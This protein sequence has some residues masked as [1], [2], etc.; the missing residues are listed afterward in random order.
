MPR[1]KLTQLAVD[2]LTWARAVAKWCEEDPK[3]RR[4]KEPGRV[5]V[6][7]TQLAEFGLIVRPSGRKTWQTLYRVDGKTVRETLGTTT[8]V[9]SVSDARK[10]G[11]ASMTKARSG[12]NPVAEKREAEAEKARQSAEEAKK[13]APLGELLGQYLDK[14]PKVNQ[15]GKPLAAEYLAEIERALKRDVMESDL[16]VR[17]ITELADGK[18]IKALLYDMA[19]SR[20]SHARH[21]H[22]YLR[23]AAEWL[24]DNDDRVEKNFMASIK[25]PAPKVE[26]DRALGS[27]HDHEVRLFW[28]ACDRVEWPF[29]DFFKLLLLLGPRRD[30][31]AF[32]TWDEFDLPNRVWRL[33]AERVKNDEGVIVHLPQ[34]A[35]D[36]FSSLKHVANPRNYLFCSA[37]RGTDRPI[38]GFSHAAERVEKIMQQMAATDGLPP[39][40]HFTRHD[41][42]RSLATGMAKLGVAPHVAD[43]II[44]HSG[45]TTISGVMK[46]YNR[47]QYLPERKA[48]LDLWAQHIEKLIGL[49]RDEVSPERSSNVVEFAA[50]A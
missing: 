21:L 33:P 10:R 1:L 47:Y 50:C 19:R 5:E 24:V 32:S 6:W 39:I 34:L 46:V 11:Q 44:N 29:R 4:G 40:K 7:D 9:P 28:L 36:I 2:K 37:R 35:V 13:A 49:T 17:P 30:E 25:P 43:K 12:V 38:S 27:D 15:K 31:L 26:R 45:G 23:T 18:A 8:E 14:R 41:L 20:P 48:A 16:G 3:N 42:R 22:A